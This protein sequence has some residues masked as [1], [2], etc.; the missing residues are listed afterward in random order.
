MS[1]IAPLLYEALTLMLTG[2][3]FVFI[4]LIVLIGAVHLLAKF[5]SEPAV[6]AAASGDAKSDQIPDSVLA[7]IS[8]AVH[9]Y[10]NTD[11]KN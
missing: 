5:A 4:F 10:R 7:A 11:K 3:G 8:A 1:D 9:R 2:M 6:P